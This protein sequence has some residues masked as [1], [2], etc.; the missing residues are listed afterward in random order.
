[1]FNKP[2]VSAII[3]FFNDEKF[4]TEAI[5][6]VMAQTYNNWEMLLVDDGSV[7]RS[8][9]IAGEYV[10]KYPEKIRYLEHK[11]HQ[12]RGSNASRN[13]GIE[14]AQGEYIAL[15]DSD[16]VWLPEKLEQ[17]VAILEQNPDAGMVY[18]INHH[19]YSWEGETEDKQQDQSF[20]LESKSNKLFHPPQ[21]LKFMLQEEN[22][23]PNPSNPL[24]RKEVF[25]KVGLFDG[26]FRDLFDDQIFFAKVLSNIPVFVSDK[27]WSKYRQHP[28]SRLNQMDLKSPNN[29]YVWDKKRLAFLKL[30]Q[31]NLSPQQVEDYKTREWLDQDILTLERKVK[32]NQNIRIPV[33]SYLYTR[34]ITFLD[35]VMW[36]GHEIL[37]PSTRHWLWEKIGDRLYFG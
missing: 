34:W 18:G 29:F 25:E 22:K 13:L 23:I 3:I 10:E 11:N 30:V 1:M 24:V 26:D 16:D 36:I 28:D 35:T 8:S 33:T 19:W 27:L 6:S 14:H 7:D 17:Q 37:S 20:L 5:A 12:N 4:L 2:L 15:L 9:E 21:L 31:S 32:F